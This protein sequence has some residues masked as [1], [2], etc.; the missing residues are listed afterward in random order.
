MGRIGP[1]DIENTTALDL[2]RYSNI[3]GLVEI[4]K[5]FRRLWVDSCL[6]KKVYIFREYSAHGVC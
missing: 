3:F 6:Q 5:T 1:G 2:S 4:G